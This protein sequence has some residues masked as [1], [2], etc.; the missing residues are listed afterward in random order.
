M[1]PLSKLHGIRYERNVDRNSRRRIP[2]V[3]QVV[4]IVDIVDI[5]IVI[6]VPVIA[7]GIR[8]GI[9]GAD[10]IALVLKAR[11]SAYDQEGEGID[12]E[13]VARPKVSAVAVVRNAITSVA[14][15][16]LPGAV[17]GLPVL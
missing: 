4:A 8:P 5:D 1:Q 11:V 12:A 14:A 7:P 9:D 10:P 3:I 15:A 6:V 17:V 16:L 2:A 13:A